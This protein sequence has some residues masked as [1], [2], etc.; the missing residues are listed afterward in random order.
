MIAA[1]LALGSW[2]AA[3]AQAQVAAA[4]VT[5]GKVAGVV[6]D[7]V[8]SFKGIPF[9]A[10]PVGPLRW[11]APAPVKPWSGTRKA[12]HFGAACMQEPGLARQMGFEGPLSEDCL[13]IDVW[14]TARTPN[15]RLPVI[16]WFYG[17]G[18]FS[19][20]TS[21]PL[22]DGASFAKQGVVFVSV[23]YRV[24]PFGF[25]ASPAL[26]RE[27]GG[28]SGNYGMLDMV[29]GLKWVQANVAKFGGDPAKVTIMG[30]SA[31]AQAVSR[32]SASPLA[33]GLFRGV[34]AQSGANFS[35]RPVTLAAAEA[36]GA[37]FLAGLGADD[38]KAA[39]ALSAEQIEA[40][41]DAKGAPR[42]P[43][44]IDGRVVPADQVALWKSG[45]FNDTAL[46]L[47]HTSDENAAFGARPRTPAE[48]EADV[49]RDHGAMADVVLAHYPHATDAE[50]TRS[51]KYL[52]RDTGTGW[53]DWTWAKLQSARG[54]G[55]VFA[56]YFDN[57]TA[58]TPDGSGHGSEVALVFANEDLRPGRTPW[59]EP[60]RALSKLMQAYWV[61]FARNL[62]PNGPGLPAWPASAGA[63][64][65]VMKL[66]KVNEAGPVPNLAQLRA[67]D[68]SF[69]WR[70][71]AQ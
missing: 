60:D 59:T 64:A 1:A 29:A 34:I 27:G 13:F 44:P 21:V 24:G 54:K 68:A 9:A 2:L 7:G 16:V 12:D 42:F 6:A 11:K 45:R 31:G 17:G 50:A 38:L 47:G 15:A 28:S 33:R 48:F 43:L 63:D 18:F 5:G 25:L 53:G 3:P 35:A 61:N 51:A 56:Y 55:K 32:L 49:R 19:G 23:S 10:P 70:S 14:T 36:I 20:M 69:A 52:G 26:S 67:L 57:P 62:D 22:Y 66:G 37:N 39:R 71:A 41:T 30:H 65:Q 46:L 8:S 4:S 40:A 58:R